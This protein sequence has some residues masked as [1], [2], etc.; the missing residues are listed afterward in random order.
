MDYYLFILYYVDDV[1][2]IH[3]VTEGVFKR[4]EKYFKLKPGSLGD[5]NIYLRFTMSNMQLD[6][7]TWAW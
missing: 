3:Y 5:L 4:L 7:G 1:L 2:C 6:N